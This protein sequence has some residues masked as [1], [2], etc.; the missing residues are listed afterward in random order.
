[1]EWEV[2]KVDAYLDV[3]TEFYEM[4]DPD[5]RRCLANEQLRPIRFQEVLKYLEARDILR[6]DFRITPEN[7]AY[8]NPLKNREDK[9]VADKGGI[10]YIGRDLDSP[11]VYILYRIGK[12]YFEKTKQQA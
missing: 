1:M 5:E 8:Y 9:I 4:L 3:E 6:S 7:I 11:L 12:L 10:R 2:F